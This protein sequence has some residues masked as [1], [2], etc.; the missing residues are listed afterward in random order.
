MRYLK[1][2]IETPFDTIVRYTALDDDTEYSEADLLEIGQDTVNE[3]CSWGIGET[4]LDESEVPE[5]ERVG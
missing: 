2:T 4:L 1:V 3:V 5:G